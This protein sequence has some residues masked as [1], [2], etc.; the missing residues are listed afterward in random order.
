[1]TASIANGFGHI[2]H[3]PNFSACCRTP[4]SSTEYSTANARGNTWSPHTYNIAMSDG[5]IGHF[6]NCLALDPNGNCTSPG[7]QDGTL[8]SD[9]AGCLPAVVRRW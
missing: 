6:E 4:C 1:M 2:L 3:T 5:V 8:D 7:A 9:D